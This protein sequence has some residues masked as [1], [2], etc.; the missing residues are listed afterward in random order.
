MR[1]RRVAIESPCHESWDAMEGDA[2][3]RF[4]GVCEKHVHNLSAMNHDDAQALLS[5]TADEHLCVRYS[6]ESDGTI[7]FRDLVPMARLTRGIKRVAFAA[8]M[9][10]ACSPQVDPV[11]GLGDVAISS[12]QASMVVATPDGGCNVT[13]GPFTTFHFPAG[14]ALCGPADAA[15]VAAPPVAPSPFPAVEPSVP[16]P[17]SMVEPAPVPMMG[18]AIAVPEPVD[19][20]VPCDPKPSYVPPPPVQPGFAPPPPG[21]TPGFAPPPPTRFAPPPEPRELMGDI[22]TPEPPRIEPRPSVQGGIRPVEPPDVE[23]GEVSIVPP[24]R[25]P[26]QPG[27]APPPPGVTPGFAPPPPVEREEIMGSVSPPRGER[28]GRA[29]R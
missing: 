14:H 6:A 18:Q 1:S 24:P 12:V 26:V 5:R 28:M 29:L 13:T 7:R 2:E 27:F 17:V 10:A 19:P 21:V 8:A 4:C 20:F 16:V 22:A 23:M 25:P 15:V 3:R 11:A 9:L